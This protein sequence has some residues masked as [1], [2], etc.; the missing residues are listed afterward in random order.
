MT[1]KPHKS[2]RPKRIVR[3]LPIA[4][5][6]ILGTTLSSPLLLLPTATDDLLGGDKW[7][8][9]PTAVVLKQQGPWTYGALANHIESFAGD[10]DRADVSATFFQPFVTYITQSKT[11]FALNSE[12]TYDWEG[13]DWSVPVNVVVSQLLQVG[14]QP[15]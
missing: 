12:S 5:C 11:T 15:V 4:F 2:D 9:G 1:P 14:K 6:A 10:S 13:S 3:R 8:I 7:G